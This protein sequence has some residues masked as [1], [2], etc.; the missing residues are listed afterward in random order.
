MFEWLTS[1][2]D[3]S[4]LDQGLSA[5][6]DYASDAYEG[7][8][9]DSTPSSTLNTAQKVAEWGKKAQL[10]D[11]KTPS[12]DASSWFTPST[13]TGLITGVGGYLSKKEELD[14][15]RKRQGQ[16]DEIDR[17]SAIAEI[18][19]TKLKLM[20]ENA[21]RGAGGGGSDNRA[22]MIQALNNGA[23]ARIEAYNNLATSYAYAVRGSK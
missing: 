12:S 3:N 19:A 7:S 11:L 5:I 22:L 15:N 18:E 6:G 17:L 16:K 8:W 14:Y 21:G 23:Q 9:L 10:P 1:A 4:W 2:Y 13:V 20:R